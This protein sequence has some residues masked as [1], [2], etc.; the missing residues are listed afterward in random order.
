MRAQSPLIISLP[1]R[2]SSPQHAIFGALTLTIWVLWVYLWLPLITAILWMVGIRWAY[3]Q[4]FQGT[5]GVSL[6]VILWILLS[7]IIVVASWS[8]YNNIRYAKKTQRRRAQA[9][10]KTAIR[11]KFGI[12]SPTL[13]LLLRERRL[14]LYFSDSEQLIHVDALTDAPFQ[15]TALPQLSLHTVVME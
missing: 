10:Y 9:V 5:R 12:T 8:N 6:W 2:Q 11:E 7:A 1:E 4:I 15:P 14:N 13:A 3:I